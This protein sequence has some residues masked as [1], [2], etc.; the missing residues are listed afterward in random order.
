VPETLRPV[1][2]GEL[3]RLSGV[4]KPT[5]QHYLREGLL[6]PP[7]KSGRT[8]AWY[9]PSCVERIRLIK[10]LQRRYLPLGVIRAMIARAEERGVADLAEAG[11]AVA[12]ALAPTERPLSREVVPAETGVDFALLSALERIGMVSSGGGSFGPRDVAILRAVGKMRR[13]GLGEPD[14]S[15]DDL[16]MYRDAMRALLGQEV[17]LFT[18]KVVGRAPAK[19]VVRL[20]IAAATG[21]TEL[22]VAMRGKLIADFLVTAQPRRRRA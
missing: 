5:I 8:M 7:Q 4:S 6:P 22:L 3:A 1:R 2:I 14:F 9:D 12:A 21:A 20:A 16:A 17:A 13:S 10:E 18:R 19:D 11:R 15:P